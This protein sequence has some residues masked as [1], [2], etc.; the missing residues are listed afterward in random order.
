MAKLGKAARGKRRWLG[1]AVDNSLNLR[2]DV[3][4]MMVQYPTLS[5]ARL[6]D[7]VPRKEILATPENNIDD[8]VTKATKPQIQNTIGDLSAVI[9]DDL[10][11]E[12]VLSKRNHEFGLAIFRLPLV[13]YSA[14]RDELNQ[15]K[16]LFKALTSSGKIRLVRERLGL[17]I[18]HR[19]R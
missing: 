17:P 5:H 12:E 3:E 9:D 11:V 13:D 19:R 6:Y 2:S 18:R 4:R 10:V 16:S 8:G 14:A 1:V 15:N 7:F